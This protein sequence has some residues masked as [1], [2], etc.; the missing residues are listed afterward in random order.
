MTKL[1]PNT[2]P[3]DAEIDNRLPNMFIP[4]IAPTENQINRLIVFPVVIA[5]IGTTRAF[6]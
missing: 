5:T 2:P 4:E 3:V 6:G 1:V